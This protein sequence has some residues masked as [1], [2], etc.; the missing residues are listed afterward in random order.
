MIVT[1][2]VPRA[3][4][5]QAVYLPATVRRRGTSL[6]NQQFW[7]WGQD[8]R[9]QESN[10]L[11][12]H[13][14]ERMKPPDDVQGSRC[15][16]V[17]L[18]ARRTVA[19]WGF[20]LFYGDQAHGGLYLSRFR[21]L[22]LLAAS[23]DAPVGVWTPSHLPSFTIPATSNEWAKARPLLVAAL[24][25]ISG[26]ESRIFNEMGPAYRQRCLAGWPRAVRAADESA[27]LWLRLA[28]H[29]DATVRR[30]TPSSR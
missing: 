18:D 3:G 17:R 24:R 11:L 13:G 23:A 26:Y 2:R 14:F 22:P 8:I 12:R 5:A 30:A 29:C 6:L 16:T 7:L 4:L 10:L 21:L 9:R 15:Y 19:L 20:G 28:Q 25:W 1:H 27:A